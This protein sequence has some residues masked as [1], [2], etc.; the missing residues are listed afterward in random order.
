M[1]L[2]MP[3]FLAS[4][5][6]IGLL[7]II[8]QVWQANPDLKI[9]NTDHALAQNRTLSI[10]SMLDADASISSM[11]REDNN[12][13][14]NLFSVDKTTLAQVAGRVSQPLEDG[15]SLSAHISYNRTRLRYPN[16][17]PAT[18][19]SAYNPAYEQEIGISYRYPILKGHDFPSYHQ[20]H[21]ALTSEAS[22]LTFMREQLKEKL[23]DE[24]ISQY[25]QMLANDVSL[26]LAKDSVKRANRLLQYQREREEMGLIEKAD[27]LQAEAQL[28]TRK[29]ELS[30]AK[31]DAL[32]SK[33]MMNR[34]MFRASDT[35]IEINP[36]ESDQILEQIRPTLD[37]ANAFDTAR[38]SRP[39]FKALS[40]RL[41]ASDARMQI[42]NDGEKM[43]LDV[44]T[45]V[46]TRALNQRP[47]GAVSQGLHATYPYV[48]MQVEWSSFM[49]SRQ[50][51][52]A[53]EKVELDRQ[54]IL[55]EHQQALETLKDELTMAEDSVERHYAQISLMRKQAAIEMLKLK[56]ETRRYRDGRSDTA[57]L[58]RF[59]NELHAAEV[60]KAQQEISLQLAEYRL[61]L[62]RGTLIPILTQP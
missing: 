12:T 10:E 18:F 43:Q 46:G 41:Q 22:A 51:E 55:Q 50:E 11:I 7:D 3:P 26:Q 21:F 52:N 38:Q 28:A 56:E 4:A 40:S 17:M 25:F 29:V 2:W 61:S 34:L 1:A 58:I 53:I 31:S 57:T 48:S 32:R 16:T 5:E 60:Q 14:S 62:A 20:Q 39:Y 35:P 36:V 49:P 47:G 6:P 8:Q 42:A 30:K 9:A 19:Q 13:P 59:E 15:S 44:I 24:A 33:R 37:T 45:E 54:R 23:A 27:R